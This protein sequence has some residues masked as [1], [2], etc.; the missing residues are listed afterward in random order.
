MVL[1]SYL[2]LCL[3]Y[4]RWFFD[5]LFELVALVRDLDLLCGKVIAFFVFF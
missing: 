4:F 3:F 1:G 2:F 5:F